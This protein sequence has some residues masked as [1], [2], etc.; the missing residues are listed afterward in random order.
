MTR[1]D[2]HFLIDDSVV[3]DIIKAADLGFKDTIYEIGYGKGVLTQ[4]VLEA[5]VSKL[6][7]VERDLSLKESLNSLESE[8]LKVVFG[9]GVSLLDEFSFTKLVASIPYSIT[10]PLYTMMIDNGVKFAVLLQGKRFYDCVCS[11]RSKWFYI[12]RAFYDVELIREVS[13]TCFEPETRVKSVVLRLRFRDEV[14]LRDRYVRAL[15]ERRGRK[16]KHAVA[17]SFVEVFGMSKKE[18]YKMFDLDFEEEVLDVISNEEFVILMSKVF[19][20]I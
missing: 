9:D 2:Q 7:G 14:S 17:F 11:E 8:R 19:E 13:G 15:F 10:E 16:V 6:I 1:F 18:G 20:I 12:I 5:G 4:A 3:N